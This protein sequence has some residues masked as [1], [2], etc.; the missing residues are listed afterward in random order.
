LVFCWQTNIFVEP[1][2]RRSVKP[3]FAAKTVRV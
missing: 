1:L 3:L 2:N